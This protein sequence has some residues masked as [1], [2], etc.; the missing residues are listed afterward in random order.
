MIARGLCLL[1]VAGIALP[2]D[3]A[4]F[5]D[6]Q[7]APILTRHCLGCHNRELDDGNISFEDRAT[8]LKDRSSGGAAVIPG[9]P[10][11]SP[12]I[13]AIRH[14]GDIRMPPGKKLPSRDITILTEWIRR[15]AVWGKK[16]LQ[17]TTF[18]PN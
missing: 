17:N 6:D 13:R 15:G 12:L 2:R 4:R 1:I 16:N 10:E 8:L 18:S 3:D 11:D 7:V 9:K 14:N 5:F